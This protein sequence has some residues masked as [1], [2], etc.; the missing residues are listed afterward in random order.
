MLP[1]L[2]CPPESPVAVRCWP[3]PCQLFAARSPALLNSPDIRHSA[4]PDYGPVHRVR[5]RQDG[6]AGRQPRLGKL[7]ILFGRDALLEDRKGRI[8]EQGLKRRAFPGHE[9]HDGQFSIVARHIYVNPMM[10]GWMGFAGVTSMRFT[11]AGRGQGAYFGRLGSLAVPLPVKGTTQ[12][13]R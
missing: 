3:S 11:A 7:S 4:R 1:P 8:R 12:M 5:C 2:V 9:L 6:S 10:P 13:T